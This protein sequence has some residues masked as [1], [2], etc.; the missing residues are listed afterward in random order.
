MA[1]IANRSVH[2]LQ[3]DSP[4]AEKAASEARQVNGLEPW[5][6]DA[7]KQSIRRWKPV[8]GLNRVSVGFLE[9]QP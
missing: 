2:Q 9:N 3:M 4:A 6:N 1:W 8:N 7:Q 5:Q